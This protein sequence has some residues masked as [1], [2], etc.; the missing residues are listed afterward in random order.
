MK[1]MQL[2]LFKTFRVVV[3]CFCIVVGSTGCQ[4]SCVEPPE[5]VTRR[6][7]EFRF[8]N[9]EVVCFSFSSGNVCTYPE[10][11][12]GYGNRVEY[13][14][15]NS[16]TATL[17]CEV[18][19]SMGTYSMLFSSPCEGSATYAGVIEGVQEYETDIPFQLK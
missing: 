14:K 12:S 1:D 17:E 18:W 13:K 5:S 11:P 10:I 6:T 3:A 15:V 4:S 16:H 9:G 7:I 19:E 8:A 2:H